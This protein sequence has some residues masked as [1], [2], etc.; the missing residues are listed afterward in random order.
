VRPG[1]TGYLAQ[2]EDAKDF[3]DGIVQ[4][5]EDE[6]LQERMSQQC[7]AIALD[8]YSLEQQARAYIKLYQQ[9]LQ[10]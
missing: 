8:E 5:L 3:C 7:R 9:A 2:P 10:K 4:L 1:V 6:A